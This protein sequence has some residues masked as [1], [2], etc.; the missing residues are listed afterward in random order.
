VG[1]PGNHAVSAD[2]L[3]N[4][5]PRDVKTAVRSWIFVYP[6]AVIA[7]LLAAPLF[8]RIGGNPFIDLP[9][10]TSIRA[11][12]GYT[13]PIGALLCELA[14]VWLFAMRVATRQPGRHLVLDRPVLV[15]AALAVLIGS[16][17][18][19][20]HPGIYNL[21]YLGQTLAPLS[22]YYVASRIIRDE[23][24]AQRVFRVIG[25]VA[26]ASAAVLLGNGLV[27]RG[28]AVFDRPLPNHVGFLNIYQA[29]DYLPFLFTCVLLFV[30]TLLAARR[31]LSVAWMAM[32]FVL[33]VDVMA[34][35]SRG[36]VIVIIVGVVALVALCWRS[37]R[38][39]TLRAVGVVAAALA[40]ALAF[41]LPSVSR[42]TGDIESVA[43]GDEVAVIPTTAPTAPTATP[44]P[45]ATS[46]T[47][48]PVATS[49]S[50]PASVDT[51][52]PRSDDS[53]SNSTRLISLDIALGYLFR[54]PLI[55]GAFAPIPAAELSPMI[56]DLGPNE[57][58]TPHDQ[59]V[60]Y[61]LRGGIPLL[62]AYL[63]V[64]A[65]AIRSLYGIAWHATSVASAAS[66]KALLTVLVPALLVGNFYQS[67][68]I[69]PY[70]AFM[71]WFLIG[72]V[73]ALASAQPAEHVPSAES[74]VIIARN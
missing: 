24:I 59:Y 47:G 22:A 37:D 61:G 20:L 4:V 53:Q 66:G 19:V 73:T 3:S 39:F 2:I 56:K 9:E 23:A 65:V 14:A 5:T 11:A 10:S 67:N 40:F 29:N 60:D 26:A 52:R 16:I 41:H 30:L 17:G 72:A 42:V 8:V 45:V 27:S 51:P 63:F 57:L 68:F 69:Q 18:L 50:A 46:S 55:G 70:S 62:A 33:A 15:F 13:L 36:T 34:T 49:S 43:R 44:G 38:S 1:S 28:A 31:Q 12:G 74:A 71:L 32:L 25:L 58:F 48:L 64:M 54:N 6:L 35:F 21:L 7:G